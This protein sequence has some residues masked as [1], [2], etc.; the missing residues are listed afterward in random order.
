MIDLFVGWILEDFR[1]FSSR[2]SQNAQGKEMTIEALACKKAEIQIK[3]YSTKNR[4]RMTLLSSALLNVSTHN[5]MKSRLGLSQEYG[6]GL[7]STA[8]GKYLM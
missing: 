8:L 7:F 5:E 6:N 2:L 1:H 4:N 3:R